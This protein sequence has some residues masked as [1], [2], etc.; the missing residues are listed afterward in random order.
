M[1]SEGSEGTKS[2]KLAS[3]VMKG[4]AAGKLAYDRVM[5]KPIEERHHEYMVIRYEK[6]ESTNGVKS[7]T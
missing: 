1:F 5:A 3:K 6:Y 7:A 2:A 4:G